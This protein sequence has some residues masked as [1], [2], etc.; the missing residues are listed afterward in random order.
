MCGIGF[1]LHIVLLVTDT[2]VGTPSPSVPTKAVTE[3]KFV[4]AALQS[5]DV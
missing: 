4:A 1:D 3:E 2:T 5:N